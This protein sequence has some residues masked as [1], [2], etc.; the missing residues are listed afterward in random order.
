MSFEQATTNTFILEELLKNYLHVSNQTKNDE[1][2][3]SISKIIPGVTNEQI[4]FTISKLKREPHHFHQGEIPRTSLT[5]VNDK[6]TSDENVDMVHQYVMS[7]LNGEKKASKNAIVKTESF[8]KQKEKKLTNFKQTISKPNYQ[9]KV[10][11]FEGN[12][13]IHVCDE[14]KKLNQDFTCPRD[15]LVCEM[16]YFAEYLTHDQHRLEEVDI[17]VHCDIHI[18]D[19][20]MRYVK[21]STNL[22][23]ESDIPCLEANNVIS[24]L[25]SSDFLQMDS[26]VSECIEFCHQNLSV[27]LSTPC[28]MNCINDKL[29]ARIAS[30][31]THNTLEEVKDKKDK[32][33]SKLFCK[34]I[35]KM[36]EEG[37]ENPDSRGNACFLF[38]CILCQRVMTKEQ[39]IYLACANENLSVDAAGKL[40]Y[41]HVIDKDWDVNTYIISLHEQL[42]KWSLVYWRLWSVI[43]DLTCSRC[44]T[45]FQLIDFAHCR[46]HPEKPQFTP[47]CDVTVGVYPCCHHNRLRFD[48]TATNKGCKFKDHLVVCKDAK[49]RQ[50]LDDLMAH[51]SFVIIELDPADLSDGDLNIFSAEENFC[52]I[53]DTKAPPSDV[54]LSLLSAPNLS[55]NRSKTSLKSQKASRRSSNVDLEEDDSDDEVW[56]KSRSGNSRS[57][58]RHM[59][60][61]SKSSL[62]HSKTSLKKKIKPKIILDQTTYGQWPCK[63]AW[64]I[65]RPTR[66]NQDIQREEDRRRMNSFS[67]FLRKQQNHGNKIGLEKNK[68]NLQKDFQG[69]V[70]IK[71]EAAFLNSLKGN[72]HLNDK[73]SHRNN[74]NSRDYRL[75]FRSR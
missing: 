34:K 51:R 65:N 59:T 26:L 40:T 68:L 38:K 27:I 63:R 74:Q 67:S 35:E 50:L 43:N 36:F 58:S 55:V 66:F 57:I 31:F 37:S 3:T 69:G 44:Q 62:D 53:E 52:C 11:D 13:V 30:K 8:N 7:I 9:N 39:S 20:L 75:K 6:I 48:P 64:D 2:L 21:R 19:W 1:D 73:V 17:S 61:P 25:I 49:E 33:K 22:I 12:M 14:A 16:K 72:H 5:V 10:N 4:A 18:F 71:L 32:F 15:L 54:N 47:G 23:K 60:S 28:N 24:I 56:Q 42:R 29:C 70:F 41:G 45:S 46:Y